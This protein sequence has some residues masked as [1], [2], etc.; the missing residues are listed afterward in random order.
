MEMSNEESELKIPINNNNN[1]K[2]YPS[3]FHTA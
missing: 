3:P 1:N 2:K